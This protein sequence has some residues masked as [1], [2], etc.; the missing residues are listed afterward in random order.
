MLGLSR[1]SKAAIFTCHG[2]EKGQIQDLCVWG[3]IL[4][5]GGGVHFNVVVGST[6]CFLNNTNG[7]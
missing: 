5:E 3:F 4:Y 2:N 1:M 7:K 6:H